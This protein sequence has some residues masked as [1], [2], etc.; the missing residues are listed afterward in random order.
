MAVRSAMIFSL[1]GRAQMACSLASFATPPFRMT[2]T[3]VLGE[4]L[5]REVVL[6]PRPPGTI[7]AVAD[8]TAVAAYRGWVFIHG[9]GV[10]IL[11]AGTVVLLPPLRAASAGVGSGRGGIGRGGKVV[12]E[13][14]AGVTTGAATGV[15]VG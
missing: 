15:L 14:V 8:F 7:L 12:A 11:A 9:W 2:V 5:G 1:I 4:E 10:A 3:F 6:R 13:V